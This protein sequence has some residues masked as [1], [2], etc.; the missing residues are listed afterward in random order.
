MEPWFIL[1]VLFSPLWWGLLVIS[2]AAIIWSLENKEYG[3]GGWA[4]TFLIATILALSFFG[5]PT[6]PA[7]LIANPIWVIG[8]IIVAYLA[9]GAFYS[10]IKW[11][12]FCNRQL[13]DYEKVKL[14]WLQKRGV[15]G[16]EIPESL[17]AEYKKYIIDYH[18]SWVLKSYVDGP[19]GTRKENY[20]INVRPR[21][22]NHASQI[23]L[24][25]VYWPWSLIWSLLDDIVRGI[26]IRIRRALTNMM[27]NISKMVFKNV[28]SDFSSTEDIDK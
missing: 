18:S 26:F 7:M 25:M 15:S 17:K 20:Q 23:L 9:G 10:I 11:Y 24:W 22:W 6:L 28:D 5:K 2:S 4:T 21:P 16:I 13:E 14:N 19:N 12:F 1:F 8:S 27:D 3:G